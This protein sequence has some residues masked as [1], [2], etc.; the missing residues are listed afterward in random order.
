MFCNL[1]HQPAFQPVSSALMSFSQLTLLANMT[2]ANQW[3]L[4]LAA[5]EAVH[6]IMAFDPNDSYFLYLMTSY[7]VRIWMQTR[8]RS[9]D[10]CLYRRRIVIATIR[11]HLAFIESSS[12][13]FS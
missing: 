13:Q 4:K 7:H 10:V 11:T 12:P 5:G 3:T 9:Q 6:H 1:M 8:L 2:V